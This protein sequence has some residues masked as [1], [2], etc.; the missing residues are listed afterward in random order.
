VDRAAAGD[1]SLGDVLDEVQ[2]ASYAFICIVLCLP[3]LQP[4]SLGPLAVA[5]GLTFALLGWQCLAGHHAPVLPRRVR[6]AVLQQHIWE[7]LLRTCIRILGWCAHIT[8]PRF[9]GWVTGLRG[10]RVL[11]AILLGAGLLMA[12]PFFGLPFNNALPALAIFFVCL[13]QLERDGLMIF[14]SLGFIALTLIYFTVVLGLVLVLGHEA[15]ARM[16]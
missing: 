2:E 5:G 6:A 9:E 12:L 4:F 1:L 11:G 13:G 14:V 15:I 8:A 16:L 10:H 3:F 7:L